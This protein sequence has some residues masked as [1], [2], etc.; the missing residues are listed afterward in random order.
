MHEIKLAESIVSIL[1]KQVSGPEI[2]KVKTVYLEVGQLRYIVPEILESGFKQ[3]P[4]SKKLQS[5]KINIEVVPIKVRCT[6]CESEYI[7]EDN[8]FSCGKC[9]SSKT[10]MISGDEFILKGIEW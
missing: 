4:K 9:Q 3:I 8:T 6:E 1:E 5:A 2:G 10:E 7:V